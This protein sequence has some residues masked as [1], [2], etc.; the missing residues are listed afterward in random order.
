MTKKEQLNVRVNAQGE[1]EGCTGLAVAFDQGATV[2][3]LLE[4]EDY[5]KGSFLVKTWVVDDY[6]VFGDAI[7]MEV[8]GDKLIYDYFVGIAPVVLAVPKVNEHFEALYF[9]PVRHFASGHL[10]LK[11]VD[12]Y[13]PRIIAAEMC[14]KYAK[15][16]HVVY[17]LVSSPQKYIVPL[18]ETF[19]FDRGQMIIRVHMDE[20]DAFDR[21]AKGMNLVEKDDFKDKEF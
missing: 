7:D 5:P 15:E 20:L 10:H 12:S 19:E 6:L 16:K 14:E 9:F 4:V 8:D 13:Y 3:K 17:V 11:S 21:W 1:I 18:D 2:S